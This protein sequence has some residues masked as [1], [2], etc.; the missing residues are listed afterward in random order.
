MASRTSRHTSQNLPKSMSLPT[1]TD[2]RKKSTI[3][4]HIIMY[5]FDEKDSVVKITDKNFSFNNYFGL[6][7]RQRYEAIQ[8]SA[9]LS[10]IKEEEFVKCNEISV[11]NCDINKVIISNNTKNKNNYFKGTYFLKKEKAI[12]WAW[13]KSKEKLKN[14]Y[15]VIEIEIE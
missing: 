8:M 10:D 5:K 3:A 9:L 7:R 6:S 13:S 4:Q 11:Q 12:P 15:K 14:H 1:L 2:G